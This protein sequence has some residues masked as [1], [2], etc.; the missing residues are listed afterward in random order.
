MKDTNGSIEWVLNRKIMELGEHGRKD[1]FD[2]SEIEK[3]ITYFKKYSQY[4]PSPLFKLEALSKQLGIEGIYIKDESD[5]FGLKSFKVLGGFL[6]ISKLLAARLGK[7][8]SEVDFNLLKSRESREKTGEITFACTT[9]GNHGFGVAWT[10]RQL[11]QKAVVYMPAGSSAN[12]VKR[13]EETRARVIVTDKNYD[14]TV[15]ITISD[16]MSNGWEIIQD[17]AWEGYTRIPADIIQGYGIIAAEAV[18][19]MRDFDYGRPTHIFVQAG[20]GALAAAV[21][22]YFAAAFPEAPPVMVVVEPHAANCIY[23][24]LKLGRLVKVDGGL[25]TIMAGLACGEPNPIA[26]DI[27]RRVAGAAV[28]VH[29]RIAEKGMR[30]LANPVRKDK[31]IISGESGAVTAGLVV[32]LL[33]DNRYGELKAALK[34][35]EKSKILLINTEGDT[36]PDIYK[37]I[38]NAGVS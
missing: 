33:S 13:I 4:K 22:G 5:R 30:M 18:E 15:R 28:S 7:D 26:W 10:A 35:D 8:L 27:I 29:D 24:S 3:A 9:D 20:V 32:E 12:R 23:R 36:D 16:A 37:R 14:D 19:Q 38:V 6:A 34:I 25:K 17:T 2:Y 11:D 21:T 31:R 1:L